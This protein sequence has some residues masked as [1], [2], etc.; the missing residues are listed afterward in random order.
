MQERF[1]KQVKG[2]NEEALN[3][4]ATAS[5]FSI[6]QLDHYTGPQE[7]ER[8]LEEYEKRGEPIDLLVI[9]PLVNF[10]SGDENLAQDMTKLINT[11][12]RFRNRGVAVILVHHLGKSSGDKANVGHKLRGSTVLPGWYDTH[13]CLEWVGEEGR[14]LSFELRNDE[15][16][17][18]KSLT[19]NPTTLQ[20][21]LQDDPVS[22]VAL[23]VEAVRDCEGRATRREVAAKYNKTAQWAG[24]YLQEAVERLKL[25]SVKKGKETIYCLPEY[26]PL[27]LVSDTWGVGEESA[28]EALA[29]ELE[30][31]VEHP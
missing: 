23:V 2:F 27:A 28:D 26:L 19:L 15:T 24:G 14:K 22:Q 29:L 20:F 10:H 30:D 25:V 31:F 8:T 13:L 7:I 21:E 1:N 5:V 16:P 6:I 3:N 11:A 18:V 17:E 4:V 12:N 9:D